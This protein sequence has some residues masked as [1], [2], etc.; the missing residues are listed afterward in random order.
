MMRRITLSL[1]AAT[2]IGVVASQGA[3]AA[4][5]MPRK[6]PLPVV[7]PPPVYNW[8]GFYIG[9]H[10]GAGFAREAWSNNNFNGFTCAEGDCFNGASGGAGSHNAI[11][12]LGGPTIGYNWQAPGSHWV[13]GIEG[14]WSFADLQGDHSN[15]VTSSFLDFGDLDETPFPGSATL[16]DRFSTQVEDI[17]TIAGRVGWTSDAGTMFYIKGGGAWARSKYAASSTFSANFCSDLSDG[18]CEATNGTGFWS[19]TSSK[20]G[21][22]AGAGI[23]FALFDNWSAKVE[24]DYLGFGSRT[25]QLNGSS[26]STTLVDDCCFV[27]SGSGSTRGFNINQ[28][29]QE[30]KVGLNYRFNWWGH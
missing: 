6:A 15:S 13:W 2:A 3:S 5:L 12:V 10:V 24:Y 11:G 27:S 20:W 17:A 28:N 19:G 22:L 26:S 16:N 8:T 14:E 30:I 4:D 29:I 7:V 23:E 25:V 1:L 18:I 9:G 21:W